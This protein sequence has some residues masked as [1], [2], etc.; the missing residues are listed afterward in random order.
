MLLNR[1]DEMFIFFIPSSESLIPMKFSSSL[2]MFSSAR[3][4]LLSTSSMA[5][6]PLALSL[7]VCLPEP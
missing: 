6:V 5:A 7:S 1:T 2:L 3:L 4:L